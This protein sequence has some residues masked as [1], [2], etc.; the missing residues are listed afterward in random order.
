[1]NIKCRLICFS[2]Q[3]TEAR[4]AIMVLAAN[5]PSDSVPAIR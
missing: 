1:M 4:A 3:D 5:L 2:L